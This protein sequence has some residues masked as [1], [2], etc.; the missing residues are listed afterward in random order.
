MTGHKVILSLVVMRLTSRRI[1]LIRSIHAIGLPR[2]N[3]QELSLFDYEQLVFDTSAEAQTC[4]DK[5][6]H[7]T[8]YY[9]VHAAVYGLALLEG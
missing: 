6:G 5:E 9:R 7:W 4:L 1:I 8:W 2:K 3:G